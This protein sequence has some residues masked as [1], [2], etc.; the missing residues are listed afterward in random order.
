MRRYIKAIIPIILLSIASSSYAQDVDPS[1]LE[2]LQSQSE[3]EKAREKN[4]KAEQSKVTKDIKAL[5]VDVRKI[6]SSLAGL[7]DKQIIILAELDEL[8]QKKAATSAKIIERKE[9]VTQL[10]AALQRIENNP[11]PALATSPGDAANASRAGI[12]MKG[13]TAQFTDRVT[14]LQVD[15]ADFNV[16]QDKINVS[17]SELEKNRNV[18]TSRKSSLQKQVDQKNILERKLNADFAA[19]QKRRLALA[20][21]AQSLQELISRLESKTKDI[22][23][24]IKPDPDAVDSEPESNSRNTAPKPVTFTKGDLRFSTSKGKLHPPAIGKLSKRYSSSHPGMSIKLSGGGQ[25]WAPA[26]GRVEFAGPFKNYNQVVIL[27]VGDGYYVLLTGLEQ[28]LVQTDSKVSAGD[29]VGLMPVN[30]SSDEKLYIEL[31]KNGSTINPAP[32]FGTTFAKPSKG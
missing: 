12:L 26:S 19:T 6:S 1:R 10:L 2:D 7:Q 3:A 14:E 13:L 21:E 27:N 24:R 5:S 32:W 30:S 17:K 11:P 18:M 8:D 28:L 16:I 4:I 25:I 15:L 20:Q 22:V 29:P 23:P 31:R 9:S